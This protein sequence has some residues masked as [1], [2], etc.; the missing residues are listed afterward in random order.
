[1]QDIVK[2]FDKHNLIENDIFVTESV[3]KHF[4]TD[5][6]VIDLRFLTNQIS[7]KLT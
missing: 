6:E 3:E 5:L 4:G 7:R 1:M 2:I